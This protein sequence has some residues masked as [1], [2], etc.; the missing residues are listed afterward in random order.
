MYVRE[1][2]VIK[3]YW[4]KLRKE[5]VV[6]DQGENYW[7]HYWGYEEKIDVRF[8]AQFVAQNEI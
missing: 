8:I 4:L 7:R 1:K 6:P 2:K 5:V 3:S